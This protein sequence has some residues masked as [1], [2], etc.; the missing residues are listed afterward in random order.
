MIANLKYT[1]GLLA[2]VAN[3]AEAAAS[4]VRLLEAEVRA[5]LKAARDTRAQAQADEARYAERRIEAVNEKSSTY[6]GNLEAEALA[7]ANRANQEVERLTMKLAQVV[8]KRDALESVRDRA[9]LNADGM[10]DEALRLEGM[11][12]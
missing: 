11:A 5:A 1:S 3:K 10:M 9:S 7:L 8:L 4:P 12:L 6:F 2:A